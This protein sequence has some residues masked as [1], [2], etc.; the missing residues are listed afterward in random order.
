[1]KSFELK[2][3]PQPEMIS[4][5]VQAAEAYAGQYIADHREIS[6]LSL[7]LE[8]AIANVLNY[9]LTDS[10]QSITVRGE[11]Q[12]GELKLS[13]LDE[14]LP[15]NYEELLTDE[16]AL[17]LTIM[18][19]SVDQVNI[20][21]L[22][23]GGRCQELVKYYVSRPDYSRREETQDEAPIAKVTDFEIIPLRN[24]QDALM[25]GRGLYAEYGFSYV[26]DIAYYP[27]LLYAAT[28]KGQLYSA[29]AIDKAT[30][31]AVGH[32]A[33]WE[34]PSI[35]GVWESGMAVTDAA[36]RGTGVFGAMIQHIID[37][38]ETQTDGKLHL[39]TAVTSHPYSQKGAYRYGSRPF[40]FIM[41]MHSSDQLVGT[42]K[43]D[44]NNLSAERDSYVYMGWCLDQKRKT[45]YAV[46]EI[47][48]ILESR[49]E[50][51]GAER[52]IV[53]D[54]LPAEIET[55][56]TEL[57]YKPQWQYEQ[58]CCFTVGRNF[59]EQLRR[60]LVTAKRNGSV[61][62]ELCLSM[63]KPGVSEAY[64]AAKDMGFFFTGLLPGSKQG[65]ILLMDKMLSNAVNYD[66][67]KTH[68]GA[69]A[70][71]EQ[72]RALDPDQQ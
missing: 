51:V 58:I 42:F 15:G 16:D 54:E 69:T 30:G 10:V 33:A 7:A 64:K 9:S 18:H 29:V 38:V 13:V 60:D 20:K 4:I 2:I 5:A 50:T 32:I 17:G 14:G 47:K 22:G 6:R 12:D 63:D 26:K 48:D 27:E 61:V 37:Y 11:A 52:D 36:C 21:N 35:P 46:P 8:E 71:L 62:A 24:K 70:F 44:K 40:G 57:H 25:V 41:N 56:V 59:A 55:T 23:M 66:R 28:R 19:A 39:G 49:Y 45:V 68:E 43:A 31:K 67:I 34:W 65:D 72:I 1:M 3:S 53:T